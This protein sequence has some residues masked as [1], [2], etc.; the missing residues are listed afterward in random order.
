MGNPRVSEALA[1]DV[2]QLKSVVNP[3]VGFLTI[4]L[5]L[6]AKTRS[7]RGYYTPHIWTYLVFL[8]ESNKGC[9]FNFYGVP[10]LVE[11]SDDKMEKVTFP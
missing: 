5:L 1:V 9:A 4:R 10:I 2:E 7:M 3:I 8:D 11:Q 6:G